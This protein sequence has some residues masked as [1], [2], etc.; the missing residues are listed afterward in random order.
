[1]RYYLVKYYL[2]YIEVIYDL[3]FYVIFLFCL[4]LFVVLR[5]FVETSCSQYPV[6][7]RY[8]S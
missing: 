6:C 4:S 3:S 5:I 2:G 8:A 1:M 7:L